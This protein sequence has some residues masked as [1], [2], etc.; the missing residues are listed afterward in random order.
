MR[1]STFMD[2]TNRRTSLSLNNRYTI[3]HYRHK[4][5]HIGKRPVLQQ[6]TAEIF[7]LDCFLS[8]SALLTTNT[9]SITNITARCHYCT[10]AFL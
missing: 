2:N 5:R 3:H 10:Q 4:C 9:V 6:I 1:L 7:M 8:L